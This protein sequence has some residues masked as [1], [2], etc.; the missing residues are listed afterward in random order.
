MFRMETV[1]IETSVVSLL[2]ANPSRNVIIAGQQQATRDWWQL[3]RDSFACITSD[4]TRAEAARGDAEQARLRLAVLA[5]LPSLPI[6]P[7][8]ENLAAEFLRTGALPAAA[9]S[10]AIHLAVATIV[11]GDYLLPGTVGIWPTRKFS[12]DWNGKPCVLAGNCRRFAH[13]WN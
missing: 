13:R 1:Y 4:E 6:T 9:R 7:E 12:G 11:R 8:V 5:G 2:V 3:R 10:D